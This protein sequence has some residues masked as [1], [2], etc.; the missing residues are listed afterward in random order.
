MKEARTN[1]CHLKVIAGICYQQW[2]FS[3]EPSAWG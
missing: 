1:Q 2:L 3:I